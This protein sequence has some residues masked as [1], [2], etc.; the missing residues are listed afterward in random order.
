MPQEKAPNCIGSQSRTLQTASYFF[1][2]YL[3]SFE[4]MREAATVPDFHGLKITY[5]ILPKCFI[6]YEW[7]TCFGLA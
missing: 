4:D 1:K 3:I 6:Q 2:K 7:N 5:G